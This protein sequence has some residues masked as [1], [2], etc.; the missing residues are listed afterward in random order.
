MSVMVAVIAAI[1]QNKSIND[2]VDAQDKQYCF[3]SSAVYLS[4]TSLSLFFLSCK[5][6]PA[7][8]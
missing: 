7:D 3:F 5:L 6:F 4:N 2:T 8:D 1:P